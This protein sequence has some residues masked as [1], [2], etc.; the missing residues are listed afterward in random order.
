MTFSPAVTHNLC[1]GYDHSIEEKSVK[2]KLHDDDSF[3]KNGMMS[4][5]VNHSSFTAVVIN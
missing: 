3:I 4:E 1:V 5:S 2:I